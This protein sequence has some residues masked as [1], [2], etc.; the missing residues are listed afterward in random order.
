MFKRPFRKP[1][2]FETPQDMMD[3]VIKYLNSITSDYE[4]TKHKVTTDNNEDP[5][6]EREWIRPPTIESFCL[7]ARISHSVYYD[8]KNRPEYTEACKYLDNAIV[9]YLNEHLI[10]ASSDMKTVNGI[11]FALSSRY[12]WKERQEI[13]Q[14]SYNIN[15]NIDVSNL[16]D[17]DLDELIKKNIGKVSKE[18]D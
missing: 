16:S 15:A 8:Y 18:D 11:K 6:I 9:S 2:I 7:H 14:R 1:K 10:S 4:R 17:E 12:G 5:I 3:A 13:D